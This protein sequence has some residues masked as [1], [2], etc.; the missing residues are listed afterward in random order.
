[1]V[2]EA[3]ATTQNDTHESGTHVEATQEAHQESRTSEASKSGKWTLGKLEED[4]R[5]LR[6]ENAKYRTRAKEN[7]K[8]A[9]EYKELADKVISKVSEIENKF[10]QKLSETELKFSEKIALAEKRAINSKLELEAKNAG[11]IDYD[12]F[13][14]LADT[15]KLS[16]T[17]SGDVKGAADL[18]KSLKE[19]KPYLFE[20]KIKSTSTTRQMPNPAT[21][22]KRDLTKLDAKDYKK[23]KQALINKWK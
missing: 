5:D 10:N 22:T 6:K 12:D 23:E 7:E 18:V 16:I 8:E 14:K 11:I 3:E 2:D 19:T 20:N 13:L 15:S 9:T 17:D 1:M 4:L 21:E